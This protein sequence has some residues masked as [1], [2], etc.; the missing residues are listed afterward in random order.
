MSGPALREVKSHHAIH[1]M[2]W[3]EAFAAWQL[4]QEAQRLGQTEVFARIVEVFLQAMEG[5][6]LVH[7]QDEEEGL[8]QEWL[9]ISGN[10]ES[11]VRG[12]IQEHTTMRPLSLELESAMVAQDYAKA[13]ALMTHWLELSSRHSQHEEEVIRL[14]AIERSQTP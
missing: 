10:W 13:V 3:N 12:L 2:A 6:I 5:R 7:A 4:A 9:M 14:I 8:Y 1:E 11:V